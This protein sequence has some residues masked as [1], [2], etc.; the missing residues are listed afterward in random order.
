V[1]LGT[2]QQTI[3][4]TYLE[5]DR[6]RGTDATFLHLAEE[7]GELARA[8]RT[9]DRENQI[10]ELGDVQAWLASVANLVDVRL[11]DAADRFSR[12]CPACG[13]I[14]CRCPFP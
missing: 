8:L 5:R 4:D 10:H 14:P 13:S 9:G 2:L 7:I 3:A 6:R 1:D 12:G 11:P